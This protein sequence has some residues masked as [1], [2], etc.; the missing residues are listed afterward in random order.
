MLF[1]VASMPDDELNDRMSSLMTPERSTSSMSRLQGDDE[2]EKLTLKG[3][4][5]DMELEGRDVNGDG[6]GSSRSAK[7]GSLSSAAAVGSNTCE[8]PA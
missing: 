3:C 5:V 4:D 1:K 6:K 8:P 7:K 2:R